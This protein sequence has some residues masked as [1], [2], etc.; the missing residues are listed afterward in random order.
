MISDH[1]S[2]ALSATGVQAEALSAPEKKALVVRLR[3][4]L[5]I[6]VEADAAW[7]DMT[8]SGGRRR[9]DG[10]ELVPTFVGASSCYMFLDGA[11]MVWKFTNGFD[12]LRVLKD[13]PAFEFYVCDRDAS[14]LLC[15][16][17]HDFLIGWGAA[18]PW[19]DRLGTA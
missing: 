7:D 4:R 8:E 15:S 19:V 12:L 2:S 3:E 11:D 18:R 16:N 17:H 1:V 6:D 13:C 9:S 10:W 14:Y 5:G